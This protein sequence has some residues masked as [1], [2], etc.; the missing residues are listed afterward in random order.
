MRKLI[1]AGTTFYT[2]DR[3]AAAL[4]EYASALAQNGTAQTVVIP[5]VSDSGEHG[6]FE[7]VIGPASQLVSEPAHIDW[8]EIVD[9]ALAEHL[10]Q[11]TSSLAPSRPE[12]GP[13]ERDGTW[14]DDY[15]GN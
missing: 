13:E 9:D 8:P 5:A 6:D 7:L 11:E 12:L 1:Y 4:L 15:L 3:L 14:G 2:G 10:E